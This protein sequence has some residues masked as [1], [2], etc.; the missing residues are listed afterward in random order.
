MRDRLWRSLCRVLLLQV[1]LHFSLLTGVN[2]DD[3]ERP[4]GAGASSNDTLLWGPYRPNLYFGVR[5]RI[6]KSLLTGLVWANVDSF[7][8]INNNWRHTCEQHE[9]MAGYGW[10]EYDARNGGRQV[11]QDT[12]NKID[13]TIDFVKVPGPD[14]GSW[15]ARVR[16]TPR[17]DAPANI[18][19]TILF[20]AG[21]E[22]LGEVAF[23][24]ELDQ[25]GHSLAEW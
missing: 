11:I 25:K 2:A 7:A 5:P 19:S 12:G 18:V 16:G 3:N 20:Y 10:D 15:G 9:G 8:T 14:G 17:E 23:D 13:L 1:L 6:P 21:L 4:L 22:G 24:E